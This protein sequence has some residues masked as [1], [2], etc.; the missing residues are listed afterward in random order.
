MMLS[1]VRFLTQLLKFLFIV[2]PLMVSGW[3]VLAVLLLF[4]PRNEI[5]LPFLFRWY[6]NVDSYIGRDTSVYEAVCA[7][8]WWARYCWMAW[9]NPI[10]YAG[11]KLFGFQFTPDGFYSK[12]DS[13]Q[14]SVGDTSAPGFRFIEY[15]QAEDVKPYYEY[16]LIKKWSATKCLRFRFGWKI[17][18]VS[19]PIGSYC[20]W[21]MVFQPWKDYSG[22]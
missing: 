19:N 8:G 3:V 15:R 10:N 14:F 22:S 18:N 1:I 12:V 4:I 5:K 16:Y 20:Q 17:A 21:V 2:L 11:Y 6:D 13:T 9:R 7:K